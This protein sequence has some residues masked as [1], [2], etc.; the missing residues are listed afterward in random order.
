MRL[1]SVVF[2]AVL[3]L[4]APWCAAQRKETIFHRSAPAGAPPS[5]R[6][7]AGEAGAPDAG[8][9]N[10]NLYTNPFFGFS[11]AL[12]VSLTTVT[13]IMDGQ[14]DLEQ[15]AFVLLSLQAEGGAHPAALVIAADKLLP[16]SAPTAAAAYLKH[17]GEVA[18]KQGAEPLGTR[19]LTIG[20]RKFLRA[21]FRRTQPSP[22][23]QSAVVGLRRG[24]VLIFNFA[25]AS[26]P[27]MEA[28]V[29]SLVTLKFR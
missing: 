26:Q 21:D 29:G 2:L 3:V 11:Y 28:L 1:A 15:R 19:E 25:A 7:P 14:Q 16:N 17:L 4:P 10:G 27:E 6:Q 12:P 22:G 20:G 23:F 13:D 5:P 8:D 9:I 18:A 24:Y